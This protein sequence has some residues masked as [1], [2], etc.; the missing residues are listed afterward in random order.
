MLCEK[1][2]LNLLELR[3]TQVYIHY[4]EKFYKR[5]QTCV[6]FYYYCFYFYF[7]YYKILWLDLFVAR[8]MHGEG[9]GVI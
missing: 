3:G 8:F 7:Y 1:P 9:N 4:A 6:T 2:L 5:N